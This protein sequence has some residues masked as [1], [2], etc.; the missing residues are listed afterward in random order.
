[1]IR[2]WPTLLP[3]LPPEL[4]ERGLSIQELWLEPGDDETKHLGEIYTVLGACHFLLPLVITDDRKGKRLSTEEG[5]A[6]IDSG[7]LAC[8]MVCRKQLRE[9]DAWAIYR[10][11][12][13][14]K[15]KPQQEP[16]REKFDAILGRYRAATLPPS[17]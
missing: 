17:S 3:S 15:R 1:L 14:D 11:S 4:L 2:G 13:K 9:Q 7:E 10:T 16:K 8:E 12:K 6:V 5:V